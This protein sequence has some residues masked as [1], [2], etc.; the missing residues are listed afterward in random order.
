MPLI[1]FV[2]IRQTD[3]FQYFFPFSGCCAAKFQ[4]FDLPLSQGPPFLHPVASL[5]LSEKVCTGRKLVGNRHCLFLKCPVG[6]GNACSL[7]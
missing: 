4:N 1:I 7:Q 2:F 5:T 6:T 3:I